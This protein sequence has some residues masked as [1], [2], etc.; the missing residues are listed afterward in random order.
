VTIAILYNPASGK[1][2]A[3]AVAHSIFEALGPSR[4]AL[5]PTRPAPQTPITPAELALASVVIVAGG[6]GTLHAALPALVA[7]GV[8]I[9]H[10]PCGTENLF[11]RHF[12]MSCNAADILRALDAQHTQ[13]IDLGLV[14]AASQ[15]TPARPFALMASIGPD[16]SIIHR[17]SRARR[18][19]ISHFSYLPHIARE[20]FGPSL[21]RITLVADGHTILT[22]TRGWLVIANSPQYACRI[23]PAHNASIS[24]GLLDIRFFPATNALSAGAWFLACRARRAHLRAGALSLTA[25]QVRVTLSPLAPGTCPPRL[26]ADGDALDLHGPSPNAP[27]DLTFSTL[28]GAIAVLLPQGP[29][30]ETP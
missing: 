3:A 26:Q 10:A 22:D 23:N 5:I 1:G 29:H 16:S 20:L 18:G 11:A 30:L 21:P 6:D 28:P 27:T 13:R 12:K 15:P 19:T 9:Y 7:R 4:A 8:P 2:R 14:T 25:R 24:D 17:L